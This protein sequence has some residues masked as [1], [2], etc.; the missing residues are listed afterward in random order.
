MKQTAL[1]SI[2]SYKLGHADQYPAGTTKVYSN[3]TPRST[4]HYKSPMNDNKI[5]WFGLQ[6]FLHELKEL[7]DTTFFKRDFDE[8][9]EEFSTLV[10]PFCGPNGFNISRLKNLHDLGYLPLEI[11]A[12]PEGSVVDVKIP[13]LT[14][15]NTRP[16]EY[17]LTNFLET[18]L[19]SELWKPSTAATISYHYRKIVNKWAKITGVDGNPLLDFLCHDF[20]VRGMSGIMDAAKCGSGHLL[21][22]NGTDNIPAVQYINTYYDGK[23][24]FIGG[25]VPA[26]EHSCQTSNI[27]SIERELTETGSYDG[28][29]IEEWNALL[30]QPNL[31]N[32][33]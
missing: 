18:W 24:T 22:F 26:T 7:W 33:I 5:V 15:T 17:W 6:G 27:L 16:E 9:A 28:K 2:D 32:S 13:V 1:T 31:P 3:F 4:Y 8:V 20:S 29:T 11:K 19:S 10:A 21:S 25:S 12:L 23:S 30:V 14:I